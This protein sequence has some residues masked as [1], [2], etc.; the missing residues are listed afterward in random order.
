MQLKSMLALVGALF[1]IAF[2]VVPLAFKVD[3]F[4]QTELPKSLLWQGAC[5][6]LRRQFRP[7]APR[8]SLR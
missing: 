2:G 5:L 3:W 1:A 8:R 4:E 7:R 6:L